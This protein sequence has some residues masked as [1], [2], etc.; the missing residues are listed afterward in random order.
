VVDPAFTLPLIG[1][2][3]PL[4]WVTEAKR[5]ETRAERLKTTLLWVSQGKQRNW[6]YM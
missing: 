5:V 4:E 3:A 2:L 1:H 6:K